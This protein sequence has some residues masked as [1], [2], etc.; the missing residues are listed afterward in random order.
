M[1]VKYNAELRAAGRRAMLRDK[2]ATS[3]GLTAEEG[4]ELAKEWKC[5]YTTTLHLIS[6]LVVKVS[7]INKVAI[8]YRGLKLTIPDK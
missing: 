1:F 4:A 8:L 2:Q 5:Q 6:S 7:R 3:G